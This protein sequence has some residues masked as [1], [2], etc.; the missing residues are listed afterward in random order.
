[1]PPKDT[2]NRPDRTEPA[3]DG[4]SIT[5]ND[6]NDLSVI[7]RAIIPDTTG[8]V[9]VNTALGTTL[10]IPVNSG[11]VYPIS[12]RRVFATNTDSTTVIG[13]I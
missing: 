13:L 3:L 6:T 1:M 10:T 9:R 2:Y 11:T 12:C 8:T 5:P 4:I 7:V